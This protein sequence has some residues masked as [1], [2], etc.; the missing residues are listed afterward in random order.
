MT[1]LLK[2]T[3]KWHLSLFHLKI[4]S[5]NNFNNVLSASFKETIASARWSPLADDVLSHR[6][7]LYLFQL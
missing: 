4:F 2:L 5:L 3:G 7:L 6:N 1:E